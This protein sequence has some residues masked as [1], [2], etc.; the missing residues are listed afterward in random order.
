MR[1][2]RLSLALVL[3]VAIL[4]LGAASAAAKPRIAFDRST[5]TG[6]STRANV[7]TMKSNGTGVFQVTHDPAPKAS[8]FPDWSPNHKRI[9][10][11]SDRS[12]PTKL[13]TIKANGTGIKQL[14]TGNLLDTDPAWAPGGKLIAF[15]RPG[16][17]L[18]G[19]DA[20]DVFTI[21]SDGTGL[22]KLT[23]GMPV[24]E[25]PDWSPN[26]K[27]IVFERNVSGSRQIW[28][29][30][31]D[32]THLHKLT[33]VVHGA[34]RPAYSP[35]GKLVAFASPK[36]LGN[37][38][39]VIPAGGGTV[40]QVTT[41]GGGTFNSDPAWSPDSKRIVFSSSHSPPGGAEIDSIKVGGKGRHRIKADPTGSTV[42]ESP[43]WG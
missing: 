9:V 13:W 24:A 39:F 31:P 30:H 2:R 34:S 4:A 16:H 14:T 27:S 6:S 5:G 19:E 26:G 23:T 36:A 18:G 40:K 28:S 37:E 43:S 32:G 10:F 35:N 3:G 41:D 22:K 11:A 25:S 21:H 7:F 17:V 1:P 15:A 29:M 20:L 8:Q 12:G 42:F 38:I 33:S